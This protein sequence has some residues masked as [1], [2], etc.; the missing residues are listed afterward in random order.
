M[1]AEYCRV[2]H[3]FVCITNKA[4]TGVD[5]LPIK[6]P[7]I[8]YWNKLELFRAALFDGPVFYTDLDTML[9][10]DVTDMVTYPHEF[11]AGAN[12]KPDAHGGVVLNSGLM[13]WDGRE[14]LS[15]LDRPILRVEREQYEQ[16]FAR[17][18]DQGFIQDNLRRPFTTFDEL[19]PGRYVSYKK[20]C[21]RGVPEGASIVGF[22]GTPRPHEIGWRL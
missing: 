6:T 7:R 17:W 9:I 18:G 19:F 3:R 20:D 5:C 12:W 22:H 15:Y 1:F 2:T 11:T 4:V 13:A 14:D 16:D 8:G 21:K 10:G